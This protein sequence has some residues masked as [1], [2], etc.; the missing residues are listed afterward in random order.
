MS[1]RMYDPPEEI[2]YP[3]DFLAD[4]TDWVYEQEK[5][6]DLDA[7]LEEL[8]MEMSIYTYED[9]LEQDYNVM[10]EYELNQERYG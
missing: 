9:C 10:S 8:D 2:E 5:D 4:Y 7:Y 3:E 1:D 6:R